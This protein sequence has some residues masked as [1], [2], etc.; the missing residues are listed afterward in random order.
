MKASFAEDGLLTRFDPELECV[1]ETDAS[2]FVTAGVLSQTHDGV[3]R[4]VAFFSRKMS[5]A[6]VNYEI[7]DKE[8]LAIIDAFEK[9]RPELVGTESPVRVLT[10]HRNLACYMPTKLLNRR[11]ARSSGL[12]AA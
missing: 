7:Y 12:P 8:M 3:L 1:V 11:Q 5:P 10:D 6:E 2:D 4:P 9:W